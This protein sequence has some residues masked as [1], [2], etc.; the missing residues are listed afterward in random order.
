MSRKPVTNISVSYNVALVTV[1]NLPNS[2]NIISEIFNSIA[3][4]KINIDMISQTPPYKGSIS[5]S[6]SIPSEDLVKAIAALNGFKKDVPNLH[7]DVDAD[8]TKISIYGE[9]MKNLHGVAARLFTVLA[10]NGIEMKLVTT[11]EVDISCLIYEKD[12]DR[13][14]QAIKKEYGL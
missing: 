12:V 7:I 8:N 11:S 5:L 9:E 13:A 3:R 14:I 2:I 10:A 4:Q 6:F 1:D